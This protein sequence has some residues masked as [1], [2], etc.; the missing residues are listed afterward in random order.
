MPQ[1]VQHRQRRLRLP[2]VGTG[3]AIW[4]VCHNAAAPCR[5]FST[6]KEVDIWSAE[7]MRGNVGGNDTVTVRCQNC[8]HCAV[9]AAG[10]PHRSA[11]ADVT[12]QRL[13]DPERCSIEVPP[14]PIIAGDVNGAMVSLPDPHPAGHYY[15]HRGPPG[16]M[17]LHA[18][19]D[20]G[21]IDSESSASGTRMITPHHPFSDPSSAPASLPPG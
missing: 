7:A 9:A 8:R 20:R 18:Q 13:G 21:F 11:E 5:H 12:K 14:F 16:A 6:G 15:A 17:P 19:I 1:E 4:W 2:F 10:L 3:V